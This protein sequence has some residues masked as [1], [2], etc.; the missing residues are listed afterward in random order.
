MSELNQICDEHI[1]EVSKLFQPRR[2][3]ASWNLEDDSIAT[4]WFRLLNPP[5]PE[6]LEDETVGSVSDK[7]TESQ[8]DEHDSCREIYE[9]CQSAVQSDD[10]MQ[11]LTQE[12]PG[13]KT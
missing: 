9:L 6:F 5:K 7:P 4:K 13:I 12:M 11:I 1:V 3:S 8:E 10:E 2:R